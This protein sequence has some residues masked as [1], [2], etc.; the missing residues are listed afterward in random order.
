MKQI[1]NGRIIACKLLKPELRLTSN[2][3]PEEQRLGFRGRLGMG[4]QHAEGREPVSSR[5][6]LLGTGFPPQACTWCPPWSSRPVNTRD[7]DHLH[8]DFAGGQSHWVSVCKSA[9][10][11]S[12]SLPAFLLVPQAP[13]IAAWESMSHSLAGFRCLNT[14]CAFPCHLSLCLPFD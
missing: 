11:R 2:Q 6:N 4:Q 8:L 5:L 1:S 14:K 3:K 12:D 9:N 7:N 13:L 10:T